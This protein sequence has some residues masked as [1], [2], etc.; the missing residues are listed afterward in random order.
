MFVL[1]QRLFLQRVARVGRPRGGRFWVIWL[2][3]G[4]LLTGGNI[5]AQEAVV[6]EYQIKAA[7]LYNFA[8]FVEW[9]AQSFTNAEAPLVIGVWGENPFGGELEAIAQKHQINGR[10]IVIRYVTSRQE[11][12]GRT[13]CFLAPPKTPG[14]RANWRR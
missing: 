13:C 6:K 7:Y 8:K 12:A 10:P 14:W 4:G 5:G 1:L 2:L 11:A 3:C 9:P